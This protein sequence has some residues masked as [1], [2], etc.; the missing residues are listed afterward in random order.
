MRGRRLHV[1]STA[2]AWATLRRGSP[3]RPGAKH[4]LPV[5]QRRGPVQDPL[6]SCWLD[7]S[8]ASWQALAV[9]A[10]HLPLV[11]SDPAVM[12]GRTVFRGTRVPVE[13]LFKNLTDGLLLDEILDSYPTL[14]RA[15]CE[16]AIKLR[17]SQQQR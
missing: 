6:K 13:V 12:G 14:D 5:R 8:S 10:E 2:T 7:V 16:A 1:H 4:V 15:D 3:E 11:V 9:T 17:R